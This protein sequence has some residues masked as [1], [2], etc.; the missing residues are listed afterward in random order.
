MIRTKKTVIVAGCGEIGTPIYKL[1]CAG[2]EQVLILD[3][4]YEKPDAPA[5]PVIALHIAVPGSISNLAEI[6]GDYIRVYN[7]EIVLIHSTTVPGTTQKLIDLF[8]EDKIVH[9]QVHGKHKDDRMMSDMLHYPKFI[10]TR[11][12]I[13]F[14]KA[15]HVLTSMGHPPSCITRLSDPLAGEI[16]KLFA[17][18]FF[19]YLVVW[20]QEVERICDKTGLDFEEL[21]AFTKI[22]TNDFNIKDKYPG[23]IG[24]HCVMPNIAILQKAFPSVLWDYMITSN[25]EKKAREND[26]HKKPK[27]IILKKEM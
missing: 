13:A 21:M 11:S 5:F 1:S 4:K 27:K 25:E 26:N 19:G 15:K 6:I 20:T 14:E 24:G 23:V 16:V 9:S 22:D 17:T 18:T 3:P 2:F 10:A 7:P 8:G 12:D